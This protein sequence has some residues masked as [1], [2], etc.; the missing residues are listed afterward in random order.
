MSCGSVSD[1]ASDSAV[2]NDANYINI[3]TCRWGDLTTNS[4]VVMLS[5]DARSVCIS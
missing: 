1:S 2:R 4:R 3:H 5:A